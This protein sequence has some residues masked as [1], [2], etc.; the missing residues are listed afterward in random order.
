M[1]RALTLFVC[2]CALAASGSAASILVVG[3]DYTTNNEGDPTYP[4]FASILTGDGHT[5]TFVDGRTGGAT[6]TALGSGTYSQLY[7][8]DL[9]ESAYL[10]AS[11]LAAITAFGAAHRGVVVDA[12]SYGYYYQ[13]SNASEQALLRNVATNLGLSGGGIWIGTDH[14]PDWTN[15]GNP[16]LAA[17][18]LN[19]VTG[20]YSDPV[21]YAD[22]TSVL[23]AG[24]TAT[25]LWGGGQSI[26]RAPIGL[27]P[28]GR[29][30]FIHFGH[31]P[32][33]GGETIPYISASFDLRGPREVP[34]PATFAT[35]LGGAG[36]LWLWR[37]RRPTASRD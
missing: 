14:D 29:T 8:F 12:R 1:A 2:L 32:P 3:F 30:M 16:V 28:D 5:V 37:R 19:P 24:V 9:T 27:Q 18:G 21:N 23:L 33:T 26:G 25:D 10:D 4:T 7:M 11:D 36:A 34:E 13:P 35:L 17:I 20:V 15:N 22:P 6:A 31:V